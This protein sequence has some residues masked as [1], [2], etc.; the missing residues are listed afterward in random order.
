MP[1]YA[2]DSEEAKKPPCLKNYYF[3]NITLFGRT[4]NQQKEYINLEGYEEQGYHLSNV[5][6]K[7]ITF[8]DAKEEEKMQLKFV[9]NLY[10]DK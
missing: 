7:N 2:N 10:W 6:L 8:I 4:E 5:Y 3:E 9:E 1:P